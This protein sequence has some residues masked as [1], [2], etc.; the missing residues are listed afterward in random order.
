MESLLIIPKNN[1]CPICLNE[2]I[3]KDKT[4]LI[5]TSCRH[6]FHKECLNKWFE[7]NKSCPI[8]RAELNT[9]LRRRILSIIQNLLRINNFRISLSELICLDCTYPHLIHD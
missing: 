9:S 7:T 4:E 5:V 2:E 8:C 1:N 3:I 6:L